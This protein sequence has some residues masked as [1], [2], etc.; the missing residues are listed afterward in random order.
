MKDCDIGCCGISI[1]LIIDNYLYYGISLMDMN[2][3]VYGPQTIDMT[4]DRLFHSRAL[5]IISKLHVFT[6]DIHNFTRSISYKVPNF[7][8]NTS[9]R[10]N[11]RL[12]VV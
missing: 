1:V 8:V 11:V 2:S 7:F 12:S 10:R 5:R 6:L 9:K 4:L 3:L